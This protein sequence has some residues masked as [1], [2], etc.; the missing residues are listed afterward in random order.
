MR[1]NGKDNGSL[2]DGMAQ[3]YALCYTVLTVYWLTATPFTPF[4]YEATP[5]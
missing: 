5:C 3:K 1:N 2:K 4:Q